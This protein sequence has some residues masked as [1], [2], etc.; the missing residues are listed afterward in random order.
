MSTRAIAG[1]TACG[2]ACV[3]IPWSRGMLVALADGLGHGEKAAL[4]ARTFIECVR[5]DPEPSLADM[6][7]RAHRV[8]VRTRGAVA[9]VARFDVERRSV[10]LASIGNVAAFV[11]RSGGE[12]PV[13]PLAIPG[14]L[15]SAYRSVRSQALDF[16]TGDVMVMHS[17]GVRSRFDLSTIQG[18]TAQRAADDIVRLAAKLSDDACCIV[19][20]G[21]TGAPESAG[22]RAA[23]SG[24]A[25]SCTIPLRMTGDAACAATESRAFAARAGLAIRAQW[26]VSIAV[27]ELASNVL[28]FVG[29][30]TLGMRHELEPR[31]AVVIEVVDQGHGIGDLGAAITDGWSEGGRLTPERAA[32]ARG[33]GVGLGSVHR[34]MDQ[35][36]IETDPGRGT[37]IVAR[38]FAR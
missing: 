16:G 21:V 15:G 33:L 1:E 24:P 23:R 30:G 6:F 27:A 37:R 5:A 20:R 25:T 8:L 14:V 3:A 18:A 13:H 34:M 10:E 9:A 17:D 36:E 28:K 2:D 12:R 26:E 22:M 31:R 35:V 38:K 7:E 4:A 32:A 29:T 11:L 19:V